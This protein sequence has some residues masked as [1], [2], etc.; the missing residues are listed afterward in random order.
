MVDLAAGRRVGDALPDRHRRGAARDPRLQIGVAHRRH[1]VDRMHRD[2]GGDDVDGEAVIGDR[3]S[4]ARQ[5]AHRRIDADL[6]ALER[7]ALDPLDHPFAHFRHDQGRPHP[8]QRGGRHRRAGKAKLQ[9]RL[10]RIIDAAGSGD[11]DLAIADIG[12]RQQHALLVGVEAHADRDA[13]EDQRRF[14]VDAGQ[15]DG[16]A[17]KAGLPVGDVAVGRLE[18]GEQ[19]DPVRAGNDLEGRDQH[20]PPGIPFDVHL[21][22][23]DRHRIIGRIA[24]DD[25]AGAGGELAA[26]IGRQAVAAEFAFQFA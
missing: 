4:L 6:D 24:V 18:M 7:A 22:R 17:A 13:V 23:I 11:A 5:V 2:A 21:G 1:F 20:A 25:V 10:A 16:A 12:L 15:H 9:A 8:L 3:R 26:E 14:A 19:R